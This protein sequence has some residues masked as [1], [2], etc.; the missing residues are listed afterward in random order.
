MGWPAC[1]HY[2]EVSFIQEFGSQG[3]HVLWCMNLRKLNPKFMINASFELNV[4]LNSG[5][6]D[7]LAVE[8]SDTKPE[9]DEPTNA[10]A[11][12]E[13]NTFEETNAIVHLHLPDT[14]SLPRI[15]VVKSTGVQTDCNHPCKECG[16]TNGERD[17]K[18]CREG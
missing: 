3:Y 18:Q 7:L 16:G 15:K 13:Q 8:V 9:Q 17:E 2:W 11:E 14:S 1:V 4:L 5:C 6:Y 10:T 12:M